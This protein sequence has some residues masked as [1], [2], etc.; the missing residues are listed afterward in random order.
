VHGSKGHLGQ[1]RLETHPCLRPPLGF[2]V[3]R[4]F[5]HEESRKRRGNEAQRARI[6][7]QLILFPG[8]RAYAHLLE[9]LPNPPGR[10]N[11]FAVWEYFLLTPS[12]KDYVVGIHNAWMSMAKR[13]FCDICGRELTTSEA[14][15]L[16][17]RD[18]CACC[19]KK[20]VPSR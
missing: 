10:V 11:I 15:Q 12:T 8:F 18:L 16:L 17:G 19:C 7:C 5:F 20:L 6:A 3:T 4:N 14:I 9:L 1:N 2:L 13:I